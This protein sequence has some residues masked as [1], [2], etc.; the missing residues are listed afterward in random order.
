MKAEYIEYETAS[1]KNKK[2]PNFD[3]DLASV[4]KNKQPNT[5]NFHQKPN[6]RIQNAKSGNSGNKSNRSEKSDNNLKIDD[7]QNEKA[8]RDSQNSVTL[9]SKEDSKRETL[10]EKETK[11]SCCGNLKTNTKCLIF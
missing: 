2:T 4:K 1:M 8:F 7:K 3:S 10:F 6:P 9:L 11:S 5:P